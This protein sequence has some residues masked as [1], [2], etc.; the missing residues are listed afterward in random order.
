MNQFYKTGIRYF[1]YSILGISLIK[2]L[3][4]SPTMTERQAIISITGQ[5]DNYLYFTYE[6]G[7][8]VMCILMVSLLTWAF[9]YVEV[10][11]FSYGP[12]IR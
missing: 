8:I 7:L 3:E 1:I 10:I 2:I 5:N 11:S 9:F 4:L 6:P 12:R